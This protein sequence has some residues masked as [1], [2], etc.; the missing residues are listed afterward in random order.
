MKSLAFW[1]AKVAQIRKEL[2][3]VTQRDAW[4][5]YAGNPTVR[6]QVEARRLK[7]RRTRE[8]GLFGRKHTPNKHYSWGCAYRTTR[9]Q[10]K[11]KV[12]ARFLADYLYKTKRRAEFGRVTKKLDARLAYAEERIRALKLKTSWDTIR[13]G[14]LEL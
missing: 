1:E 13:K 2:N 4:A 11:K 12:R 3:E 7:Y 9:S 8:D 6:V 14:G 5:R 10:A